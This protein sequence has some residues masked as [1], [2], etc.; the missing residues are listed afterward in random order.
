MRRQGD[1]LGRAIAQDKRGL[2]PIGVIITRTVVPV[3]RAQF[4]HAHP[5]IYPRANAPQTWNQSV[6][7]ILVQSLLGLVPFAPLRLLMVDPEL[8]A[9]L[10]EITLRGLRVG[11]AT[12]ALRF[13]RE[14]GGRSRYEVLEQTGELKVL[15]QPWVQS[16]SADLWKRVGDL[17]GSVRAARKAPRALRTRRAR[18]KATRR[19]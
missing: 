5:G 2:G 11:D 18:E 12:V 13:W 14:V 8:P 4:E 16:L 9:W 1:R 3:G 7:P 17:F 19:R 10:P 15:R 6:F